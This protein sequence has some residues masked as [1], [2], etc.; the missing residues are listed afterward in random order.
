MLAITRVKFTSQKLKQHYN[1]H[2]HPLKNKHAALIYF[3]VYFYDAL[4]LS[5]NHYY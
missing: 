4:N 2:N 3:I 1:K 5:K